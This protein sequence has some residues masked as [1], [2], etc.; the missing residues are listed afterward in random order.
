MMT[1]Q[2]SR[3]TLREIS[4]ALD[5][6][7]QVAACGLREQVTWHTRKAVLLDELAAHIGTPDSY[8]VAAAAWE[9][10]AGLHRALLAGPRQEVPA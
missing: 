9:H 7:R 3:I 8:E 10:L 4:Q 5:T 1:D 2:P 6:A